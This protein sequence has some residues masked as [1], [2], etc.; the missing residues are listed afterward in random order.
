M[1]HIESLN[2]GGD[3]AM[4]TETYNS[5]LSSLVQMTERDDEKGQGLDKKTRREIANSN[6][7]RRM[8]SINTGFMRLK[9]LVPTISKEKV[10]KATILQQTAEHIEKLER[11]NRQLK[12]LLQ[13]QNPNGKI[14]L[15]VDDDKETKSLSQMVSEDTTETIDT[16]SNG[17]S[18]DSNLNP[19]LNPALQ[20]LLFAAQL[21]QMNS[22]P[23]V[24]QNGQNNQF[25]TAV[26]LLQAME[27]V[28]SLQ[29]NN[30][31]D[32]SWSSSQ[33]KQEHERK[34][35]TLNTNTHTPAYHNL[36]C[37]VLTSDPL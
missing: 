11:E 5:A 34:S 2:K 3:G 16:S 9:A 17:T 24:N 12:Q 25:S 27:L 8:Q 4:D 15:K 23:L 13:K 19:T 35:D 36:R 31:T 37:L 1:S 10:S 30:Q 6:E 20:Q 28:K 33:S 18:S 21:K 26:N 29:S 7:R 22:A 14:E 32:Q